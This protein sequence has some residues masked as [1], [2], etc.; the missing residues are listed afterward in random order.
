MVFKVA[1][2]HIFKS[3][4]MNNNKKSPAGFGM[5]EVE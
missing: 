5:Y 2:E 4:V 3:Y 1:D